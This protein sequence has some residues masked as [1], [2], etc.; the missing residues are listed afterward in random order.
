MT[1]GAAE[2]DAGFL[3]GDI[4]PDMGSLNPYQLGMDRDTESRSYTVWYDTFMNDDGTLTKVI[5]PGVGEVPVFPTLLLRH[6]VP[7]DHFSYSFFD[8]PTRP[9]GVHGEDIA[10]YYADTVMGDYSPTGRSCSVYNFKQNKGC[11][12]E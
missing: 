3:D 1:T 7:S 2:G 9:D 11:I 8:A 6:I 10:P 12:A 5:I 4:D